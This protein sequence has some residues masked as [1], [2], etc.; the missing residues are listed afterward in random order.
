MKMLP[1]VLCILLGILNAQGQGL[2]VVHAIKEYDFQPLD[3]INDPEKLSYSITALL[4]TEKEKVSAIFHWITRNISYRIQSKNKDA[5]D[6]LIEAEDSCMHKSLDEHVAKIVLESRT[7]VC[8]G[9]A[10]LF[11]SMCDFAGIKS[12][13]ITGY[14]RTN[15][16]NNQFRCNHKWNAVMIDSVWHLLDVTWASG[17]LDFAGTRFIQHYNGSYFLTPPASFNYDHYPDDLRWTLL[18]EQRVLKEFRHS[19]FKNEAFNKYKIKSFTPEKGIIEGQVGDSI[20]FEI[21][22]PL[23]NK[24]LRVAD[25]LFVDSTLLSGTGCQDIIAQSKCIGDKV[26]LVYVIPDNKRQW[27]QVILNN[28]IIMRYKLNIIIPKATN[29]ELLTAE[30]VVLLPEK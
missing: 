3:K 5:F 20:V 19:P 16:G 9:Y 21:S 2:S 28:D 30:P 23:E 13:V 17:Y 1:F 8:D 14:A 7:A 6:L 27:I 11:K 25:S 12:E 24:V 18:T 4:A 26:R 29:K 10:R 15:S 22:S